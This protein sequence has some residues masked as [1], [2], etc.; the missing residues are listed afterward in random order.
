MP[1]AVSR[2]SS[3]V[4]KLK[5][6]AL[7]LRACMMSWFKRK[8]KT[9]PASASLLPD[10]MFF[11]FQFWQLPDFGQFRRSVFSA[12]NPH[13]SNFCCKQRRLHDFTQGWPLR[14]AWVAP[15]WRKGGPWVP[16]TQSQSAEGRKREVLVVAF[17]FSGQKLRANSQKPIV[18]YL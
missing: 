12:P 2:P 3:T 14:G 1:W 17:D 8:A 13:F 10:S 6:I 11:W 16:Q 7:K 18:K 9:Y 4:L 15:G 5:N